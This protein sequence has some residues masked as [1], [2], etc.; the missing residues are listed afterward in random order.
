MLIAGAGIGTGILTLPYAISR[1]GFLG[2][3]TAL[4]AAVCFSFLLYCL[5]ADL[6]LRS[7]HSAELTGI[8]DEHLFSGR[9]HPVISVLF[10]RGEF[11]C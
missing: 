10:E 8:L 3:L 6:T 9:K 11:L 5:V 7:A 4:F 1:I 2:T